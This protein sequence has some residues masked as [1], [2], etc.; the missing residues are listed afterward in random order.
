MHRAL[1]LRSS[2]RL[3]VLVREIL[4]YGSGVT[5][6]RAAGIL[7]LP[8][9]TRFLSPEQFGTW[10]FLSGALGLLGVVLFAGTEG[11]L[12]RFHFHDRDA[13]TQGRLD[14]TFLGF[15]AVTG[16]AAAV[17]L[18]PWAT[19]IAVWGLHSSRTANLVRLALL[20]VPASLLCA[21]SGQILRS[22]FAASRVVRLDTTGAVVATGGGV[23]AVAALDLG[24]GGLVGAKAVSA[25][26]LLPFYF[27]AVGRLLS[28]PDLTQARAILGRLLRFGVPL[29]PA[30]IFFWT[31]AASDR[32]VLARLA[33]LSELGAYGVAN[34]V[35]GVLYLVHG[36]VAQAWAPRAVQLWE[37]DRATALRWYEQLLEVVLVGFGSLAVGI[38]LLAPEIVHVLSPPSF[39]AAATVVTPLCLGYVAL[40][41]T[42]LT[43]LGITF[44]NRTPA[45]ALL[46]GVAALLNLALNIAFVPRWG[47]TAAAGATLASYLLLT[48]TYAAFTRA[49]SS[50]R[51]KQGRLLAIASITAAYALAPDLTR[52]VGFQIP[53]WG[54]VILG[55]TYVPVLWA[56]GL[57][58]LATLRSLLDPGDTGPAAD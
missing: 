6:A 37:S 25:W 49:W 42:Q 17:L 2:G 21:A 16:T 45:F 20:G 4:A 10:T 35:A 39:H 22:R 9:L 3:R 57:F 12:I 50:I 5:L 53:S 29:M 24:V 27:V 23:A 11:A 43:S 32:F 36:A 56:L 18:M 33:G 41:T 46:G 54:R 31:I 47:M 40:A 8:I 55:A 26:L 52:L 1:T 19:Q 48:L 38:S 7:S 34:S 51:W 58:G 13:A 28:R 14:A 44:T 15:V 30:T